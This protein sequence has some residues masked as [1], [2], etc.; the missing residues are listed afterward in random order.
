MTKK[1]A[2]IAGG[3]VA[4][5][6]AAVF[7]DEL[8]FEVSLFEKK[9]I[10]GG[11]AYSFA[12]KKTGCVVDNGQ[13]LLIGAYHETIGLLER[14]GAKHKLTISVPTK[15]PLCF[16]KKKRAAFEIL[17]VPPPF[18]IFVGFLK[19]SLFSLREKFLLFKIGK[20]LN[21]I[22]NSK[23]P[24]PQGQTVR[25]WLIS[26]GQ[27]PD[28][29]RHFWEILTLATLN[30]SVDFACAAHLVTVLLKSFFSGRQDGF[31]IFPKTGLSELF[32]EPISHYL[33]WRGQDVR[34]SLGLERVNILDNRVQS[35][36][37]S[38][39][40]VQKADLFVCALPP[41]RL[42]QVL[43]ETFVTHHEGLKRIK[44]FSYSP[45]VSINL[46]YDQNFMTDPF[47]GSSHTKVHWFFNK[48]RIFSSH[49]KLT[50]I[51]GV[52]S[53]AREFLDKDREEIV[54]I[55]RQDL[56]DLYPGFK[57][58]KLKH[59]TVTIERQATV[60]FGTESCKWRPKQKILDNF[61]VIGDWTDT[62]L[63]ATIE[64]AVVS[65]KK[66]RAGF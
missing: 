15:I 24:L 42:S 51:V 66:I 19:S 20:I 54:A 55:A 47:L 14:V 36:V 65:A 32:A 1:T 38:D 28:L 43:P 46:F 22:K 2:I 53:G 37:L 61:Y 30:D 21:Q 27:T 23:K 29:I 31:L 50:H 8:G 49:E 56:E 60:S 62:G 39:G 4:G 9:P 3:G 45:I 33:K 6:A 26:C 58:A 64:S 13:H 16:S 40:L 7:L 57:N 25:E 10:L 5:L 11:R 52:I 17:N 18:G 12:D 34:T 41:H 35:F 63:P 48:N 44:D 59:A